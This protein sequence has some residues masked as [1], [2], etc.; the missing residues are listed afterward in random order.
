VFDCQSYDNTATYTTND[1]GTTGSANQTVTACGPAKTGALTMG[2][3]Q[4]K[5]GQAIITGGAST[6][7][8]CNSGTWL[9]QYNPFQDLS[10]TA[11]CSQVAK[12]VSNIVKTANARGSSMNA[13][14]KAQMLATALDVY[15]SDPSL[16]G[17]RIGAPA[18]IGGV[19]IDVTLICTDQTC[20]AFEDVSSVF[21]S[22][23][24]GK[25]TVAA[26]LSDASGASNL[27]GSFW[28]GN[29]KAA[30]E[31]AKDTFDAINNQLAFDP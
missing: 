21:P 2:F 23:V 20:S 13:M 30:Q 3:W 26:L 9:R 24:Y 10:A 14:L 28:Y 5:N 6:G 15:F 18:P 4:N 27:S 7:G 1:S 25:E 16:G 22:N 29:V 11:S 19:H 17:N 8:V 12:Y 31:L